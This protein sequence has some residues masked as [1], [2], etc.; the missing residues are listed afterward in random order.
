MTSSELD[1]SAKGSAPSSPPPVRHTSLHVV[2]WLY[3]IVAVWCAMMW[4]RRGLNCPSSCSNIP[5]SRFHKNWFA[6]LV[7]RNWEGGFG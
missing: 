1:A 3:G 4:V 2:I 7:A 5:G 6:F